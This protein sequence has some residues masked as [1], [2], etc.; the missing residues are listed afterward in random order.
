MV[1]AGNR[2]EGTCLDVTVVAVGT[3]MKNSMLL[4]ILMRQ[5]IRER[6]KNS[7]QKIFLIKDFP[8]KICLTPWVLVVSTNF[9]NF[10]VSLLST[11]FLYLAQQL[12]SSSSRSV[13][14]GSIS[15]LFCGK[16]WAYSDCEN[17]V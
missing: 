10:L 14:F 7:P 5:T 11:L 2:I 17:I 15:A 3:L 16:N 8:M 1:T 9:L 4:E 6:R 12:W 13:S